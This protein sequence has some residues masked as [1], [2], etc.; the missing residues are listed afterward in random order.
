MVFACFP[1][2]SVSS[3][4]VAPAQRVGK[5]VPLSRHRPL[6]PSQNGHSTDAT[7]TAGSISGVL[8]LHSLLLLISFLSSSLS[9]V[10][11]C[12]PVSHHSTPSSIGSRFLFHS[13]LHPGRC[14]TFHDNTRLFTLLHPPCNPHLHEHSV[15]WAS[16]TVSV[17]LPCPFLTWCPGSIL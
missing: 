8:L 7:L 15:P 17:L 14:L 1:S 6:C 16:S 3:S 5:L 9:P 12:S 13:I 4:I 11:F 10:S 2:L